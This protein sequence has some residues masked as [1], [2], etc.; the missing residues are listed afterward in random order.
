MSEVAVVATIVARPGMEEK[1]MEQLGLI[2]G[3]SRVEA[4]ALQYDLHRDRE[5]PCR[6]VCIERWASDAA[7]AAHASSAHLRAFQ[8]TAAEWIERSEVRVMQRI[9]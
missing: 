1:L 7:L 8:E 4:G 9:A 3:P 2:V 5:D 6:F